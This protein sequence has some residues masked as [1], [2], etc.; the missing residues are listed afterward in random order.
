MPK[1]K[2]L[3]VVALSL[4]LL[5]GLS[6][7]AQNGVD[8]VEPEWLLNTLKEAQL[9]SSGDVLRLKHFHGD[10]R[11]KTANTD[12]VQVTAIAQYRSDDPRKPSIRFVQ[13][14]S[15][16]N[17]SIHRLMVDFAFLEIAENE[18]WSK[19]RIDVGLL[20]PEG[21]RIEIE[22]S[23]GLIEAKKMTVDADLKTERGEISYEGIGD[24]KAHSKRG[25]IVARLNET[26]DSHSIALSTLTGDIRCIFLEGANASVEATTRGPLTTDYSIEIKPHKGSPLK[27][28]LVQIGKGGSKVRLESHSGGVRLQGLIV[29]EKQSKS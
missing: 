10:V 11:I 21:L 5:P 24:L 17:H 15:G 7:Y 28:G 25:L 2:W 18:S 4:A 26:G 22:T 16:T 8:T 19:R 3:R 14:K 6:M 13:E 29:P 27:Q 9:A 20:I 23:D 12:R 1:G